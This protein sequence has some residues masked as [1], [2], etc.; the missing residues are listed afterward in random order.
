MQGR[1][2]EE[3]LSQKAHKF[4]FTLGAMRT[5]RI[6][7]QQRTRNEPRTRVSRTGT[8][9]ALM[10][11]RA[12]SARPSRQKSRSHLARRRNRGRVHH[13]LLAA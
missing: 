2:V 5:L 7:Y 10:I 1:P 8:V 9:Y 4:I 3:V 11:L 13:V 12:T 6:L